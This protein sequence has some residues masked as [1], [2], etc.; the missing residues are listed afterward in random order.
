MTRNASSHSLSMYHPGSLLNGL[1]GSINGP[2]LELVLCCPL[3]LSM[4][5]SSGTFFTDPLGSNSTKTN[6]L[7]CSVASSAYLPRGVPVKVEVCVAGTAR[8]P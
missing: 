6:K 4:I 1:D 7:K 5:W 3:T 2:G 8:K